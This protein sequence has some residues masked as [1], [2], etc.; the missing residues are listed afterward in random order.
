V[1]YVLLVTAVLAA[2]IAF[3]ST[4]NGGFQTQMNT[5][6]NT[7]VGDIGSEG[8]ELDKSHGISNAANTPTP[9]NIDVT[10]G[11]G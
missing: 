3:V 8:D 11:V 1:E 5:T 9:Y 10:N 7:V 6:L 2:I 4:K